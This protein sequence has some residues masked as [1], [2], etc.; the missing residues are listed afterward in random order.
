MAQAGFARR[1]AGRPREI[2]NQTAVGCKLR[3]R[4]GWT[5]RCRVWRLLTA[6]VLRPRTGAAATRWRSSSRRGVPEAERQPS[7]RAGLSETVF[8]VSAEAAECALHPSGRAAVRR[9]PDGRDGLAPGARA[10]TGDRSSPAGGRAGRA[11]RGR[12]PYVTARPEWA[13]EFEQSSSGRRPRST[14]ST[15]RPTGTT[16]SR[17]GPGSTSRRGRIRTRGFLRGD[18][19]RRGRGDRRRRDPAMRQLGREVEL[20]QG[21]GIGDLRAAARGRPGRARRALRARRRSGVSVSRLERRST[22][23]A[24]PA[25]VDLGAELP[26]EPLHRRVPGR[27]R[28]HARLLQRGGREPSRAPVRGGRTAAR[29]DWGVRHGP[30]DEDGAPIPFNKLGLTQGLRRGRPGHSTFHIRT[31]DDKDVLI[32]ASAMP[33]QAPSGQRGAMVFFWPAKEGA[34]E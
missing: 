20:H 5:A 29:E 24:A 15:G 31:E 33:I 8:V 25:R 14:R 17:P 22:S 9:A 2:G 18:R 10:R 11:L 23:A 7:R 21:E 6:G 19:D 3:S 26:L 4:G 27:R 16:S 1:P 13:P 28:G 32:E 12:P 30:F 34:A